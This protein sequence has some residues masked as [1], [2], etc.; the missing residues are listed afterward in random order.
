MAALSDTVSRYF[1]LAISLNYERVIGNNYL[2]EI[3][4]RIHMY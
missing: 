2:V 4:D 3:L 1:P